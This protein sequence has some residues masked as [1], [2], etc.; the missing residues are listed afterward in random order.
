[1]KEC[2]VS[3][4][5]KKKKKERKKSIVIL[6]EWVSEKLVVK[7]SLKYQPATAISAT[8]PECKKEDSLLFFFISRHWL[9]LK[10]SIRFSTVPS[11]SQFTVGNLTFSGQRVGGDTNKH[12]RTHTHTK[13]WSAEKCYTTPSNAHHIHP[14]IN[15]SLSPL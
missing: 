6:A 14:N 5:Q 2:L 3:V 15:Y 9:L 4:S 13:F 10:I 1:M 8:V 12:A 11:V 7:T